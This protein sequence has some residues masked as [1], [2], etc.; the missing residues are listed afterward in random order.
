MQVV[1]NWSNIEAMALAGEEEPD[2]DL[3][4]GEVYVNSI[5]M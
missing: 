4:E 1:S 5:G 2:N 3:K